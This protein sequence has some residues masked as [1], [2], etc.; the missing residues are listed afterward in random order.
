MPKITLLNTESGKLEDFEPVDVREI[1]S[2]KDTIYTVPDETR[3]AIAQDYNLRG[4]G[5]PQL[6]GDDAELQTG[7]SIDKYG[8]GNVVRA[9][10]GNAAGALLASQAGQGTGQVTGAKPGEEADPLPSEG[11]TVAE[12]KGGLDEK[13]VIYE[14]N[15]LKADLAKLYDAAFKAS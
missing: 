13:G 8:R 7:L 12:L 1:L 3:Q 9:Q 4:L 10:P 11:L 2:N 6:Q 15:A 14:T 5:I